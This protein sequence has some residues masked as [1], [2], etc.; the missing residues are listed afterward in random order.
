[1]VIDFESSGWDDPARQVMGFVAHA[2]S[3]DLP[4]DAVQTFLAAYASAT[5]LSS[6]DIAR[7]ER[8]GSLLD[9]EWVAI[10]A[11]A[12][13]PGRVPTKRFADADFD[14]HTLVTAATNRVKTALSSASEATR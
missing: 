4:P 2:A 9:L 13:L 6:E 11:T 14:G 3:E 12:T 7:Y 1:T 5:N 8:I 10:Y